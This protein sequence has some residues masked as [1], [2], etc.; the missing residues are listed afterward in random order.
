LAICCAG[1]GE[2]S[3]YAADEE[4]LMK[5]KELVRLKGK[6]PIY[7]ARLSSRT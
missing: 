2:T 7:A 3:L 4:G 1:E 5:R 6:D